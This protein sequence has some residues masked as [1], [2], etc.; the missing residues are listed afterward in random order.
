MNIF[1]FTAHFDSEES[2]RNHFKIER[3]KIGVTCKRCSHDSHYW[4]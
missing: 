3:D 4:I 2:C 1:S